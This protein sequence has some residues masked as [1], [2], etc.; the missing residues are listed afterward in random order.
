MHGTGGN[1]NCIKNLHTNEK[2]RCGVII[3]QIM[4]PGTQ[5]FQMTPAT[6]S[7]E[8]PN[9]EQDYSEGEYDEND[10]AEDEDALSNAA[11]L[12]PSNHFHGQLLAIPNGWLR[13]VVSTG[14]GANQQRKV[15]HYNPVGK[16][17]SNQDEI[18]Q[19]FA[20]LGYSVGLSLFNFDPRQQTSTSATAL[21]KKSG[22]SEDLK[23]KNRKM[24]A[25][26]K[27][28]S[29]GN[30]AGLSTCENNKSVI[31]EGEKSSEQKVKIRSRQF[32]KCPPTKRAKIKITNEQKIKI[33]IK[34][35]SKRACKYRL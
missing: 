19:Y 15:Y 16:R 8:V 27:L 3:K 23:S 30:K 32:T 2:G 33:P 21:Q 34:P 25:S 13:K 29:N 11:S 35:L 14:T 1:S 5:P 10:E 7:Q 12:L 17:F 4:T 31:D 18:D 28:L 24:A 6:G 26:S 22:N 9:Q 20:K